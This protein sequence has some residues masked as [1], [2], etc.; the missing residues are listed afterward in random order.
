[1]RQSRPG[2]VNLEQVRLGQ[3]GSAQIRLASGI[4]A[5]ALLAPMASGQV[6][7]APEYGRYDRP[8]DESR[9]V[10][11]YADVID[12][13]YPTI[14]RINYIAVK[15]K[16][17]QRSRESGN[18]SGVIIDVERGL[19]L[20]NAHV[21]DGATVI[22]LEL[23]DG[24][25]VQ[26]ELV[27]A[28]PLTDLAVVRAD[29]AG[30]KAAVFV[31]SRTLRVGDMV[32]AVG[33]PRGLDRTV[34][35]GI[36]SGLNRQGFSEPGDEPQVEDFI[37]TDAAINPGNSGGPLFDSQGRVVGINTFIF[38]ES[39]GLGFAVPSSVAYVVAREL[40]NS[41]EMRRGRMGLSFETLTSD[42]ARALGV[43][44][45]SG[46]LVKVVEKGSAAERAGL[47]PEDVITGAGGKPISNGDDLRN[48]V[49][50]AD[51]DDAHRLFVHRGGEVIR[52]EITLDPAEVAPSQKQAAP[53]AE[54]PRPEGP[55][56]FGAVLKAGAAGGGGAEIIYVEYGS[57]AADNGLRKGDVVIEMNG[58][59]IADTEQLLAALGALDEPIA[60]LRIRRG[61][62]Q[63]LSLFNVG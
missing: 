18:G 24:R 26:G 38:Q 60:A 19:V 32:F 10:F 50:L 62:S 30:T 56:L 53:E 52:L 55:D 63:F 46:A 59:A 2:Q 28:D 6:L 5:L 4:L 37:Q 9:G 22:G 47:L 57:P 40:A 42:A 3:I 44:A 1:M 12:D 23:H 43:Q 33:F 25:L 36:I 49:L 41:G 31:D 27:G 34:S 16:G 7:V 58:G 11:S 17:G 45:T 14:V 29:L 35:M 54:Q 51:L 8:F 15:G 48:F 13:T 20:T 21:V 61:D 39:D